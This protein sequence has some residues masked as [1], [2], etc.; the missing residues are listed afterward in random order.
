MSEH[1]GCG[2]PTPSNGSA[3][4]QELDPILDGSAQHFQIDL[5][6]APQAI[7]RFQQ[8][9]QDMRDLMMEAADLINLK[10]PGLDEVSINA[11]NEIS[12]WTST[13]E[14]GSLLPALES[15]AIQL[16]QAA[17]ALQRSLALHRD[18]DEASAAQL[19]RLE[20]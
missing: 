2:G 17:E 1:G 8:A 16:E 19:S 5:D 3:S 13:G 20:L 9:A 7:T 14:P 18:T 6:Q 10:A 11:A 15:G 12:R 4:V